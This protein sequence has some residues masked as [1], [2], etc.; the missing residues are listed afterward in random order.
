MS[1][2]QT[3]PKKKKKLKENYDTEGKKKKKTLIPREARM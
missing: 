1:S 3:Y 2:I